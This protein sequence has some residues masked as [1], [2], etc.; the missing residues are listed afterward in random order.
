LNTDG[1]T[2]V[3]GEDDDAVRVNIDDLIGDINMS[4]IVNLMENE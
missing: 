1:P 2:E 3:D 4:N